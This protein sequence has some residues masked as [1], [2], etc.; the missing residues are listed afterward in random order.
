MRKLWH[1]PWRFLLMM[2]TFIPLYLGYLWLWIRHTK[3]GWKV[4]A[5][6]WRKHHTKNARRF[7]KLAVRMKGG[8]IK[9]G[10]I[11]STRVDIMPKEWIQE[12]E[13]LQDRVD[14]LPWK[15]IA[16]HLESELGEPPDELFE[17]ISHEAVAAASFGQ[18]HRAKTKDGRDVALKVKYADIDMKLAC[19]L[20]VFKCAV[21][22]FN[23][24]LPKVDLKVIHREVAQALITELDYRQEAE[25]TRIIGANLE[26]V[27]D[28]IVPEVVEEY[29]TG[30]VICTT[31]FEGIKITDTEARHAAGLDDEQPIIK[32]IIEAYAHMFFVDGV[33]QSDPHP[34]NLFVRPGPNGPQVCILDFGQVKVLPKNFQRKLVMAS[35]AFMGR[36]VDNFCKAIVDMDVLSAEDV[37]TARPLIQEFFD[38]LYEMSPNELKQLDAEATKDK[39]MDVVDR[40]GDVTIPQ[41]IVLYGRAFGLLG[42]VIAALDPEVNGVIVAKPAIMRALMRPE[43][44]A[45]LPTETESAD[46]AAVPA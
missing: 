35:I 41:D 6:K 24:F 38:D 28:V 32:K 44:F 13:G 40:I 18:V 8:L 46:V 31:Y 29:T 5:E 17:E 9:V 23:I 39:I 45:P 3:L 11:I 27:P 20:F 16:K 26:E 36:D 30:S 42:G 33:F 25:H 22:L 4:P 21:P 43:N 34:G 14:P 15:R 7:Y 12:L 1:T 37:E 19:D 2:G 10:Q